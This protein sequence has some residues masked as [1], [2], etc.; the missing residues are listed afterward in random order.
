LTKTY[1]SFIWLD[2]ERP[3]LVLWRR[4]MSVASSFL[5][6]KSFVHV[7]VNVHWRH[8]MSTGDE[9]P[10]S[11]I[12]A[13][14]KH[15]IR[16]R[17]LRML[18]KQPMSFMEMVEF[19]GVSNSFL[20]YH[21]E[22]LGELIGKTEDGKYRLSSFGEAANATMTKVEDI[23]TT[24][25][26]HSPKT[27][28]NR[29]RSRGVA[30]ALGI[31]CVL[32]IAGLGGTLAYYTVAINKK[33]SELNSANDTVTNLQNQNLNLQ[34]WLNGNLTLISKIQTW[35]I[36]NATAYNQLESEVSNIHIEGTKNSTVW[37]NETL[38]W[39]IIGYGFFAPSAG[40]VSVLFSSNSTSTRVEVATPEGPTIEPNGTL[41]NFNIG[42]SFEF[43]MG[44]SGIAVFPVSPMAD[45][46]ITFE[47]SLGEPSTFTVTITYYF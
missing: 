19:L 37:V 33:Q 14:L 26:H 35:L 4:L 45:C 23:P 17:I 42:S 13:S 29:F 38:P 27:R 18:S 11:T 10:Y 36:G 47:N 34:A 30:L 43:D 21:L 12:F 39:G 6:E 24:S 1:A 15:P 41:N 8:L 25:L 2:V 28:T 31:I 7:V 3:S 44:S 46:M 20:T 40:Y 5:D 9:E 32:L 16:R 22:N